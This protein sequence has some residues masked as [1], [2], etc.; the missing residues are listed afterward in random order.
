GGR[1]Y[2]RRRRWRR[3]GIRSR[4]WRRAATV[5]GGKSTGVGEWRI[6]RHARGVRCLT[7]LDLVFT[8]RH[9]AGWCIPQHFTAR[10]GVFRLNQIALT[11]MVVD[12]A[13]AEIVGWHRGI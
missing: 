3:T 8:W 4:R 6:L 1:D 12:Q 13:H 5:G 9:L 2:V 11:V 7:D 10:A